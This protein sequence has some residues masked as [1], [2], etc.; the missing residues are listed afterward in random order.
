MEF[1]SIA[2]TDIGIRKKTNQDS[3]LIKEALTDYGRVHLDVICDGMGG[4]AKGEVASATLVRAFSS[5]FEHE[6]PDILYEDRIDGYLDYN[7]LQRSL[8]QLADDVNHTIAEYG[9]SFHAPCG[10]TLTALLLAEE[11]YYIMNIGDSRIY[12]IDDEMHKLTKDHTFVQQEIDNGRMTME[13]AK[14]HPQKN[15]LL[16]C[17]GASPV[18]VP[19]FF[20]GTYKKGDLF[21]LCSDGFRHAITEEEFCKI[22][23]PEQMMDEQALTDAAVYCTE[24]NKQRKEN[25]NISVI[26]TKVM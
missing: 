15:V 8:N 18:I 22:I 11:K 24:L 1:L 19:D 9:E 10:T 7:K 5:W 21:L 12:R 14:H 23:K 17:V 3:V 25:D 20:E 4:L 26:L 6:F 2:H 16:Q 13:E